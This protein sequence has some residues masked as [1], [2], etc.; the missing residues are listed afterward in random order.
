MEKK[1]EVTIGMPVYNVERFIRQTMDSVLSQ[2]FESIEFLICDDCGTDSSIDIVREYQQ[3]H[4]RGKDIRIVRQPQNM[5]LGNGRNRMI[6]ESCGRYI[7]FM[8]SDDILA[9]D[10]IQLLM[11]QAIKYDADI[12]YGSMEKILLYDNNRHE[13]NADYSFRVFLKEELQINGGSYQKWS[14]ELLYHSFCKA[15]EPQSTHLLLCPFQY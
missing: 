7:Y 2:T 11:E 8:D 4:P 6:A 15:F 14:M 9:P 13:K 5:G 1:Y 3:T 12:V 10:A